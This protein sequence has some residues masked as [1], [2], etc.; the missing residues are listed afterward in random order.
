MRAPGRTSRAMPLKGGRKQRCRARHIA[1][2][3]GDF[4]SGFQQ[5]GS[6][7]FEPPGADL[8]ALQILQNADGAIFFFR[9]VAQAARCYGRG[10]DACR[11]KNSGALHPCPAAS[12][13][14][15]TGALLQEGPMVQ[16]ILAR[17]PGAADGG[18]QDREISVNGDWFAVFQAVSGEG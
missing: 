12:G 7:A 8:G 4:R 14:V 18:L 13:R 3:D 11:E 6:M 16:M 1:R 5:N 2:S 17:R 15:S 10:P 9:G